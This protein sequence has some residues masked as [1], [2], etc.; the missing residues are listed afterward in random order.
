MKKNRPTRRH[1]S[2]KSRSDRK[3]FEECEISPR[4]LPGRRRSSA[5]R[6]LGTTSR[7]CP[8]QPYWDRR[9]DIA[10]HPHGFR[11]PGYQ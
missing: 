5:P 7:I 8:P 10:H 2:R 4:L 1:C 11:N 3:A 9:K 6:D